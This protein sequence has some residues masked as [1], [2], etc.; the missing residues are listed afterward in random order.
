MPLFLQPFRCNDLIRLGKNNDSGYLIN[1]SDVF[2][3]KNLISVGIGT[4]WSFEK[5]FKQLND[6]VLNSYD[7]TID[8]T[9]PGFREFFKDSRTVHKFIN[10]GPSANEL[11]LANI[12]LPDCFLKI[13]IE[14]NE[15]NILD[16][17]INCSSSLSG[18]V[19]EFHDINK[20]LSQLINFISKVQLTLIHLHVNNYFYWITDKGN[21]PDILEL[22]FTSSKNVYYDS[23]LTL[24]H[25]LDQP[26]NPNDLDFEI[27][28]SL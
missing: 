6:V 7:S 14:G 16:D 2:K 18:L 5:D 1:Q 28:F 21:F 15:Y 8:E 23:T 12:L 17:L 22:T 27:D 24:P 26:N 3:T 13:D 25:P 4:D 10:V 9:V 19:I 11:R 20:N